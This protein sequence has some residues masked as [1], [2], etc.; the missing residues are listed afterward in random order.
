MTFW[1]MIDEAMDDDSADC[2]YHEITPS[3]PVDEIVDGKRQADV[4]TLDRVMRGVFDSMETPQAEVIETHGRCKA[5]GSKT[6]QLGNGICVKCWD[7]VVNN[8][9]ANIQIWPDAIQVAEI[10]K[11]KNA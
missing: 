5:C 11:R 8:S 7:Y 2:L 9:S 6:Q 1:T 3:C 10:V 4:S